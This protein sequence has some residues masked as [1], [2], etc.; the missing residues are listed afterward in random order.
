MK[1]TDALDLIG[2]ASLATFAGLVWPPLCLLV[3]GAAALVASWRLA[4]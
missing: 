3:F 4:R 2:I 1:V